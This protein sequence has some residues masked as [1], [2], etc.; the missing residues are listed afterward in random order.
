M[1][2][3]LLGVCFTA[4]YMVGRSTSD[5]KTLASNLDSGSPSGSLEPNSPSGAE[6]SAGMGESHAVT[7]D[8]AP[9]A[10]DSAQAG[11][12][13]SSAA[14]PDASPQMAAESASSKRK[15]SK[16]APPPEESSRSVAITPATGQTYLQVAAVSRPEAETVAGVLSKR[17]FHAHVA[18]KPGTKWYRVL[19]GPVHDAGELS[20]TRDALM[21]K[22]FREVFVQRY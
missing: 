18:P 14:A 5:K 4:G 1:L 9:P 10:V 16:E 17:G 22:G 12:D 11:T 7:P 13:A 2:A 3:V 21:K 8:A 20:A 15:P 19:V 6:A